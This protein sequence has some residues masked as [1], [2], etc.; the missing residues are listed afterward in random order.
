MACECFYFLFIRLHNQTIS[1]CG[2]IVHRSYRVDHMTLV[3]HTLSTPTPS[4]KPCKI[5]ALVVQSLKSP[6]TITAYCEYGD[7]VPLPIG[8]IPGAVVILN[9]FRLKTSRSGNLYCTNFAMSSVDVESVSAVVAR[10]DTG[11]H[12]GRGGLLMTAQTL[13][14]P[15]STIS[16]L[17][18]SLVGGALSR[19][20]VCVRGSHVTTCRL[21][22]DYKCRGCQCT[23]ASGRCSTACL[24]NR[25]TME[26]TAR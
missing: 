25:P 1:L 17:M 8:L 19:S 6:D 22:M 11:A 18:L 4:T 20:C 7:G 16:E 2:T 21:C 12:T 24:R 3:G 5:I 13:G 23:I 9:S 15:V 26:V 10:M 14:V